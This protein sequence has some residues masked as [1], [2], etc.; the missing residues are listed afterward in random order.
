MVGG[1]DAGEFAVD[2]LVDGDADW[3]GGVGVDFLG[4]FVG[5]AGVVAW[6]SF[7]GRPK[8]PSVS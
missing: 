4:V 3:V 6:A 2:E 5:D 8:G 7:M 1:A